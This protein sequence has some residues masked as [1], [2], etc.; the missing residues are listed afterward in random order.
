MRNVPIGLQNIQEIITDGYIYVDKTQFALNLIQTGK[1]YFLSR[2]RRFG[3]SLFVSTLEEIFKGNKALFEGCHIYESNYD[4]KPYPVLLLDFGD[5][6]NETTKELKADLSDALTK[7]G[8]EQSITVEGPSLQSQLKA[9]IKALAK[10]GKVVVLIDEYDKPLIDNLHNQKIAEGNRRLLQSFFGALKSLDKHIKFTFITGISKFSKVSLFSGANH[11]KDISMDTRYA[12]MM[13][14]T[15]EELIQCFDEHIQAIA[16]T[17]NRKG[18]AISE[19]EVLAEIK[20][21][22]NGYRFS[23]E[24]IYVYNPFSTLNYLDEKKANSYWFATGT[25]FF[26]TEQIKKYSKNLVPL[27]GTQAKDDE[28]MSSGSITEIDIK[29]L[30]FQSGYL[31]IESYNEK[32]QYYQLVFPNKEV[33]KAFIHSLVKHFAKL[34][35]KFSAEMRTLLDKHNLTVFFEKIKLRFNKFPYQTFSKAQ[36][37]TYHGLL[38]SLLNGM[39]LEV[40]SE[41]SSSWGRLDLLIQMPKTSYVIELKLDSTPEAGLHQIISKGYDRPYRGQGK[42]IVR[43]GLS[44]SSDKRNIDTWQGELL[45]ENGKL[46]RKLAPEAK[47]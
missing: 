12:A 2:P 34:N 4:W 26:L 13:G 7:M 27:S 1:H 18:Q 6:A 11:L 22:Y 8:I 42:S 41:I 25:P 40:S 35:A 5:I 45:D 46:I 19:E 16:Q 17:R 3:K 15:Q 24:E 23:E 32:T 38:L 33:R 9:L 39:D 43:V 31:T 10:N 36:E 14:Y 47:Q 21:W 20:D 28:L 30:M 37:H 44:F 29:A